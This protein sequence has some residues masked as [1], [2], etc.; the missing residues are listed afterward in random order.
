MFKILVDT[1]IHQLIRE[2]DR[3][4]HTLEKASGHHP[5][6]EHDG[7]ETVHCCKS[8]RGEV[9]WNTFSSSQPFSG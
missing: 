8:A 2:I 4:A 3:I 1:Y 7:T 6:S 5:P 9:A